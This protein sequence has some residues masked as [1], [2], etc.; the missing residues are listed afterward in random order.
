MRERTITGNPSA[1]KV[2]PRAIKIFSA[3]RISSR[4]SRILSRSLSTVDS[5][6]VICSIHGSNSS[7]RSLSIVPPVCAKDTL[8]SLKL[9]MSDAAESS[10]VACVP[11][12]AHV[13]ISCI[14][15]N[16]AAILVRAW[17]TSVLLLVNVDMGSVKAR[18]AALT[19]A[20]TLSGIGSMMPRTFPVRISTSSTSPMTESRMSSR[21]DEVALIA[22][23]PMQANTKMNT[24]KKM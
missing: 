7:S 14:A 23:N 21:L 24:A 15:L 20:T 4:A 19:S 9:E 6:S 12:C 18:D 5:M 11:H 10:S 2:E 13:P 16:P 8:G 22:A 1:A 17:L 3:L